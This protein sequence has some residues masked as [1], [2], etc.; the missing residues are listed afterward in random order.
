MIIVGVRAATRGEV[1]DLLHGL[2]TGIAVLR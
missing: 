1:Y 2:L